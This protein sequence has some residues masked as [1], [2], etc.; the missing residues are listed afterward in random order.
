MVHPSQELGAADFGTSARRLKAPVFSLGFLVSG[1]ICRAV[2]LLNLRR[3]G[4]V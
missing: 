1:T 2:G 4:G 3:V